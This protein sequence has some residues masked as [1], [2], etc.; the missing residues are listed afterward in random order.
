M[1]GVNEVKELSKLMDVPEEMSLEQ[2]ILKH[3]EDV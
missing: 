1:N 2:Q 3:C